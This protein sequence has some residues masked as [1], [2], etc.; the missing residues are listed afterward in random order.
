MG[1][2]SYYGT[3]VFENGNY[4]RASGSSNWKVQPIPGF[5]LPV[6]PPLAQVRIQ[7][8]SA[9]NTPY[10]VIVS[11]QRTGGAPMLCVNYGD[12]DDSGFSVNLFE[13]VST[14]T[15]QNGS[16]SFLVVTESP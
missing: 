1:N 12:G 16:F 4:K 5:G 11:P 8:D 10:T 15:L 6:G 3:V 2:I 7:F 9:L 14:R 13:P